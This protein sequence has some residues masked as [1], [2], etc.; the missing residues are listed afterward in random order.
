MNKSA[1]RQFAM[2]VRTLLLEEMEKNARYYQQIWENFGLPSFVPADQVEQVRVLRA[3][4]EKQGLQRVVEQAAALWFVRLVALRYLEV[5]GY[6]APEV[7]SRQGDSPEEFTHLVVERCRD[8]KEQFPQL[9]GGEEYTRLLLRLTP[10]EGVMA[11]LEQ[12]DR[13]EFRQG[14]EV[15]G[16]LY[17][18]FN[19]QVKDQAFA[20]LRGRGR[21]NREELVAV[22]QFFTPRWL[23]CYLV[24][25]S[26]GRVLLR[27]FPEAM[28]MKGSWRYFVEDDQLCQFRQ[29]SC[30]PLESLR[31]LD[32]CMGGGHLLVCAF[33]MLLELYLRRGYEKGQAARSIVENNLWGLDVDPMACRLTSFVLLEKVL[34]CDPGALEKGISHHLCT[35]EDAGE[36]CREHIPLLGGQVENEMER[37]KLEEDARSLEEMFRGAGEYGSLLEPDRELDVERLEM[38]LRGER[39][40][41]QLTFD[42]AGYDRTQNRLLELLEMVQMLTGTYDVVVTNPPYMGKR[43]MSPQLDG[44]LRRHYPDSRNDLFAAF[45]EK[46]CRL[47]APDGYCAMLTQH[48][49][50]FL[51]GY[52]TLREKLLGMDWVTLVH[53]GTRAF[54]EIDGE[55]VQTAAFVMHAGNTPGLRGR[56]I[57]LVEEPGPREKEQAFLAGKNRFLCPRESFWKLPGKPFAYWVSP[58]VMH[59]FE[60]SPTIG[61]VADPRQGMATTDTGRFL[62]L[63][64]EIPPGQIAFHCLDREQAMESGAR[65]F[66]INK[67]GE[68]RKWYGN[69]RTVVNYQQDGR[70]IKEEVLRRYPYLKN[71]GFVV[72]NQEYYFQGGIT[73]TLICTSHF[74]VR[75][76][77]A[78]MLFD[79][80]AHCVF[81]EPELE[82]YLAA[83][84]N[85]PIAAYLLEM[86]NP[87]LNFPSGVVARLPIRV[88]R[89]ALP[90]VR[91][92][93]EDNIRMAREDW[94][95]FE[96]SWDFRV[97]PLLRLGLTLEEAFGLWQEETRQRRER[98]R[99][100]EEE[101]AQILLRI[102][103]LEQ[104]LSAQVGEELITLARADKGRE[105]RSLLSWA[106]GW[107]F[108]RFTWQ[109]QGQEAWLLPLGQGYNVVRTC[110]EQVL[111]PEKLEENLSF[112][113]DAL[114]GKGSSQE[115]I[116]AYFR[117]DFYRE[118]LR[119]YAKRP[120]YWLFDNGEKRALVYCH[121]D[122]LGN[123]EALREYYQE[124]P[125]YCARL[126]EAQRVPLDPNDGIVVN[127]GKLQN[128]P[129][130]Q[131]PLVVPV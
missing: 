91:E 87:T 97:H 82:A 103:G 123:M 74:G 116:E 62:R 104:E 46:G 115:R 15:V 89:Q 86:L 118:H 48:A 99:R 84:L 126:R 88:D 14:A 19:T 60:T 121:H 127:Y 50:L 131:K 47:T 36:I 9:F 55:V 23:A 77:P 41:A 52:E 65:W 120:I 24:E 125:V 71:P 38:F 109:D 40:E 30:R 75:C 51:S 25:N 110:L 122:W 95:S 21:V 94:D 107:Y 70:E 130:G 8:W 6:S 54:E 27:S 114:G 101:L 10:G 67:G 22:T 63:W 66:P 26:L 79:V 106:V 20:R 124:D 53:L 98:T 108:G 35:V 16:W 33:D 128:S 59:L 105:V 57:R 76:F 45:I 12:L 78:G 42:T 18:A 1:I 112:V 56:Y 49:F 69:N 72:K 34:A 13:E 129:P 29:D 100:N 3:A 61:Q 43:H 113:A 64:H 92:L 81:C 117:R 37:E 90:R 93:V 119:T 28:E 32:P 68:F 96:A 73:W 4:V 39:C 44:Y 31:V 5:N 7:L 80:S 11:G 2:G 17:Q 102:H 111:G 58:A 85:S 83:Y